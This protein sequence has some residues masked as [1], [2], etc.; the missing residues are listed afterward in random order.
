MITTILITFIRTNQQNS[1]LFL[2][3]FNPNFDSTFSLF[4]LWFIFFFFKL[5]LIPPKHSTVSLMSVLNLIGYFFLM[6]V[7][8]GSLASVPTLFEFFKSDNYDFCVLC[9]FIRFL[10]YF[11]FIYIYFLSLRSFSL[12]F[13]DPIFIIFRVIL[14]F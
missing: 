9:P 6:K 4:F 14:G 11:Y 13:N 8:L 12:F 7:F 10:V 5:C 2:K 3:Y 1:R